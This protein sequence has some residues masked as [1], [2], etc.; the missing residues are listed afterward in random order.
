MGDIILPDT[1]PIEP[2][3]AVIPPRPV[4]GAV[5]SSAWGGSVHDRVYAP[6]T[7]IATGTQMVGIS[8]AE[9]KL[10][11]RNHSAGFNMIDG[12]NDQLKIPAGGAGVY[13]CNA[14]ISLVNMATLISNFIRCRFLVNGSAQ[15]E[16]LM[17]VSTGG[18]VAWGTI[19]GIYNMADNG[20]I[21]V[22]VLPHASTPADVTLTRLE[23]VRIANAYGTTP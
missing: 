12:V 23:V 9:R 22:N 11:L 21:A 1:Q 16:G 15:V 17:M 5:I 19:S 3:A 7:S 20:T 10:T 4:G 6:L 2:F 18:G 13:F 8:G 14:A